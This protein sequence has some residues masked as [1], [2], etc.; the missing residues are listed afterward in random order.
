MDFEENLATYLPKL[1]EKLSTNEDLVRKKVMEILVH[2]NKR[3]KSRPNVQLPLNDLIYQ[4]NQSAL[5]NLSFVTNFSLIYI[6][7]GVP[8]LDTTK[9]GEIIESLLACLEGK[10]NAHQETLLSL[11]VDCLKYLELNRNNSS[12][13]AHKYSLSGQPKHRKKLLDYLFNFILLPYEP[14]KLIV[15]KT[16]DT[17]NDTASKSEIPACMSEKIYKQFKQDINLENTDELEQ[18]KVAILKFLALDIYTN[19]EIL[20]HFIIATSDTRYSVVQVAELHIKRIASVDWNDLNIVSRLFSLFIGEK[21][22]QKMNTTNDILVEPAN[23]RIRLKLYPYLLRS[24]QAANTLPQIIQLVFDCLF[25]SQGTNQKI[26]HYT[27]QFVHQIALYCDTVKL[28]KIGA[29]LIQGLNKVIVESKDDG[30]LRGLSYIA[31]GKLSK[32]I[33]S[34]ISNDINLV[35]NFFNALSSEDLDTKLNIQE[36]LVLMIDAFKNSGLKERTYLLQLL[37]EF[38]QNDVSHCRAMCVKYAFDIYPSDHLESRYLLLIASSDS[39]EDIRQDAI[40][41][42]RRTSD[43]DGTEIKVPDFKDLVKFIKNKAE[44]KIKGNYRVISI[45][46]HVL[47]FEINTYFEVIK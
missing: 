38:I 32:R 35:R 8:R 31:I 29:V 20:F 39:K 10:S 41:Y 3:V 9:K 34:T 28:Q 47:P 17:P 37:F 14:S 11:V 46:S 21:I 18:S 24:R 23:T 15:A 19:E 25:G 6:K 40:K 33:P 44:E 45:G 12:S 7:L 43:Y 16:N 1:I 22:A 27:L 42:L 5:M 30:K 13:F 36:A 4:F 26:K 2:V